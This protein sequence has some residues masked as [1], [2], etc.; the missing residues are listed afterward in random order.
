MGLGS[1]DSKEARTTTNE[2]PHPG[3]KIRSSVHPHT[4]QLQAGKWNLSKGF[5]KEFKMGI[6]VS[7]GM[8]VLGK[9]GLEGDV[10]E[11]ASGTGQIGAYGKCN[12][13]NLSSP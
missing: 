9:P 4:S 12:R 6:R 3:L 1:R 11:A 7:V 8:G 2:G 13:L 5:T 10:R